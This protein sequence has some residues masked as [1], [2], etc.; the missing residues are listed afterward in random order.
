MLFRRMMK[1]QRGLRDTDQDW[2]IIG[3]SEPYF[4]VLTN[5]RFKRAN[6]SDE[7]IRDF[8]KSGLDDIDRFLGGIRQLGAFDPRSALDFG[9]GVGRLTTALAER[10]GV[11]TGVD[12]SPG[13][14][15]EARKQER[16]G[17]EFR[18]HIPD[19]AF[20]WV[21]SYIVL[22]HIPPTR[23][24]AILKQLLDR[25]SPTGGATIQFMF[26]R[27]PEH[28]NNIGAKLTIVD[29]MPEPV[30]SRHNQFASPSGTMHVYDYDM[31]SVI[32]MF[33][34]AGMKRLIVEHCDHGGVIGAVIHGLKGVATQD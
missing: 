23:G 18:D 15:A 25:V 30:R 10:I 3:T 9:C 27:A 19:Q 17:L 21:V 24:Y 12:V 26:A 32:G 8:Y 5:D 11:A 20:D 31:S 29:G 7:S 33:Y 34:A 1:R 6:L 14:L 13:M 2:A 28:R 4:G 22:Q 16:P